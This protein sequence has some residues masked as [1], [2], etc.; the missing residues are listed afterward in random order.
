MRAAALLAALAAPPAAAQDAIDA[1]LTE[2]APTG[3]AMERCAGMMMLIGPVERSAE[4]DR[5]ASAFVG[6][7]VRIRAAQGL[8]V[9]EADVR[10]A[11][12]GRTEAYRALIE[13]EAFDI[14]EADRGFCLTLGIAIT[15]EP[16]E[17]ETD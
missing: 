3:A 8:P 15:G 6:Q 7:V 14:L 13:A 12:L 9:A 2:G 17:P 11:V 10:E 4:V 5:F 16:S 1:P